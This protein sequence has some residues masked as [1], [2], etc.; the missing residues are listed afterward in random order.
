MADGY[1]SKSDPVTHFAKV[2]LS[3]QDHHEDIALHVTKI[4]RYPIILG[5][6]WLEK[7]N[8]RIHWRHRLVRFDD[9]FCNKHCTLQCSVP[10]LSTDNSVL[11][12]SLKNFAMSVND[13][14]V[15]FDD[16]TMDD[17]YAAQLAAMYAYQS[18]HHPISEIPDLSCFSISTDENDEPSPAVLPEMYSEFAELFK[19]L[20]IGEL[21]PHRPCNHAIPLEPDCNSMTKPLPSSQLNSHS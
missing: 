7:H 4:Y 8:P 3:I 18:A 6:D 15:D 12:W 5:V 19:D 21:P 16:P 13:H 9:S 1:A 17:Y 20:P 14:S 2:H 11:L 10:A